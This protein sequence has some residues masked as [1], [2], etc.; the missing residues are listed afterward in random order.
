M[1]R[2]VPP[3]W[4]QSLSLTQDSHTFREKRV[5]PEH[6]RVVGSQLSVP[7][8]AASVAGLH[9]RHTPPK[10]RGLPEMWEQ[11]E[12]MVQAA[13]E[14]P[15]HCEALKLVQSM[16]LVPVRHCTHWRDGLQR[17]VVGVSAQ[18]ALS[19]ISSHDT[20]CPVVALHEG[21]AA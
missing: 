18:S 14:L 7:Q 3:A 11:W 17:G 12:S 1:Q 6:M 10:Q 21:R 19:F 16:L 2:N 4:M 13:H 20:H 9:S 5:I 8:S 15:A